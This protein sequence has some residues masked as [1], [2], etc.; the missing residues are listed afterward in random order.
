LFLDNNNSGINTGNVHV[1]SFNKEVFGEACECGHN[2]PSCGVVSVE[3]FL[4]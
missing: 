3:K 1:G 4:A 2:M